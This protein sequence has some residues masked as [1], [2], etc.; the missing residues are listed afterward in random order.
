VQF[1]PN[2]RAKVLA[3]TLSNS[4]PNSLRNQ[5]LNQL[6]DVLP[7][8]CVAAGCARLIWGRCPYS[9]RA[10]IIPSPAG[11]TNSCATHRLFPNHPIVANRR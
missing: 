1:S 8:Q 10:S 2:A 6:Q 7:N 3:A 5:L 9:A 4:L 11:A